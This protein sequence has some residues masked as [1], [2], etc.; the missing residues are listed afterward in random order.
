MAVEDAPLA[1]RR[2]RRSHTGVYSRSPATP[3]T[4]ATAHPAGMDFAMAG[5]S[6]ILSVQNSCPGSPAA[7]LRLMLWR[8]VLELPGLLLLY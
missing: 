5:Y 4:A 2:P 1:T 7:D 6:S 8:H 3:P